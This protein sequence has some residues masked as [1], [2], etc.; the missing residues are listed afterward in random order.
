MYQLGQ[1]Y[2]FPGDEDPITQDQS[3]ALDYFLAASR[4]GHDVAPYSAITFL[5]DQQSPFFDEAAGIALFRAAGA[6]STEAKRRLA[7]YL[8]YDS[9]KFRSP[10]E[11]GRLYRECIAAGDTYALSYLAALLEGPSYEDDAWEAVRNTA[12]AVR[13]YKQFLAT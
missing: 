4:Q 1:A 11:A 12:E 13:L 2:E 8:A 3:K 6:K 7:T 5:W 10:A 9:L